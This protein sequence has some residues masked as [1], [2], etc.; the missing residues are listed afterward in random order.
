M[1]QVVLMLDWCHRHG[2]SFN[3]F[4]SQV[5]SCIKVRA[6]VRAC[7]HTY[8]HIVVLV[9]AVVV[10]CWLLLPGKRTKRELGMYI[11]TI[12]YVVSNCRSSSSI[13]RSEDIHRNKEPNLAGF[14]VIKVTL[15]LKFVIL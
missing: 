15:I 10:G 1:H 11:Y 5:L 3:E 8:H 12:Q 6:C 2:L 9:V 4:K 14:S 7:T 13:D